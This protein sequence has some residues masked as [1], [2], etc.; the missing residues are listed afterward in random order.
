MSIGFIGL[1]NMGN[2]IARNIIR[3]GFELKV[4]DI[5]RKAAY[6]LIALGA[7]WSDSI[8]NLT[9][10]SDV[11]ITSLPGPSEVKEVALSHDGL[12]ESAR[13]DSIWIDLTTN[14]PFLVKQLSKIAE[15]RGI[16]FLECPVSQ[17]VDGAESG[18]LSIFVS[19]KHEIFSKCLPLFN[20]I[21]NKIFY[22][23]NNFGTGNTAK[24]LTNLLWFVHAA[25]IGEALS[26]GAKSGIDLEMLA[27]IIRNSAGD[28]WVAKHDIPSI[29]AGN[30]DPSFTLDL[31]CKDL[32]LVRELAADMGIPLNMGLLAESLFQKARAIYGGDKPELFV[33]KMLEDETGIKLNLEK[34]K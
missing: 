34:A 18:T 13:K 7:V 21:G 25:A 23:G 28:S 33:V 3:N 10:S 29:Y 8:S 6:N 32:K 22:L 26:I 31:C 16:H 19:G 20:I 14:S 27:D 9:Y 24:L 12:L 5:N 17:A 4:Y 1:G 11:I 30:Y 2:P 15:S